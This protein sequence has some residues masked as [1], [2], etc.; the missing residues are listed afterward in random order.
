MF[1]IVEYAENTRKK[2]PGNSTISPLRIVGIPPG[3]K[4]NPAALQKFTLCR[5]RLLRPR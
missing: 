3:C 5:R 1:W 4:L 2:S